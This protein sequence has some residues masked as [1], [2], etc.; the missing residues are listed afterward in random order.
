MGSTASKEMPDLLSTL[1]VELFDT[2]LKNLHK[3]KMFSS[4]VYIHRFSQLSKSYNAITN[5]LT[6]KLCW[7]LPLVKVAFSKSEQVMS[8]LRHVSPIHIITYNHLPMYTNYIQI[9][10]TET[11]EWAFVNIFRIR[12]DMIDKMKILSTQPVGY[13]GGL[14]IVFSEYNI[15][16]CDWKIILFSPNFTRG[17][18]IMTRYY[19]YK[20][21][22]KKITRIIYH[23]IE[24]KFVTSVKDTNMENMM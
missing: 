5:T 7:K 18:V 19:S 20:E 9:C 16:S 11:T 10:L 2:I 14:I 4:C 13:T 6:N 15:R 3:D 17:T 8:D 21:M 24:Y 22:V 12:L 23:N 1:P